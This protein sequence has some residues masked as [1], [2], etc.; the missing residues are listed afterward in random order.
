MA[1]IAL[2]ARSLDTV[3]AGLHYAYPAA[4]L[5]YFTVATCA[6]VC[7]L[8]TNRAKKRPA[9]R[10]STRLAVLGLLAAFVLAHAAVAALIVTDSAAHPQDY[11]V[12]G[13]LSCVLV[14]SVLFMKLA[15]NLH[16]VWYPHCG[17]WLLGLAFEATIHSLQFNILDVRQLA[18]AGARCA[19]LILLLGFALTTVKKKHA[20]SDEERQSLLSKPNGAAAGTSTPNGDNA[21]YGSAAQSHDEDN[22]EDGEDD[23]DVSNWERSQAK[24]RKDMKKRLEGDGSWF[25][26][27]KEFALFVPYIWP[28]SLP[29]LQ[30]RAALVLACLLT[31]NL[32]NLLLPRQVAVIVDSLNGTTHANPWVAV[33]AYISLRFASSECGIDLLSQWLWVP[34]K[35]YANESLKRAAFSHMMY[36]SADFHDS[37]ST[38]DLS[39]A[40]N[41]GS[42]VS[43]VIE[44]V[45]MHALPMLVDLGVAVVYLSYTF[46]SYEGLAT[47]ATSIAFLMLAGDLLARTQQASRTRLRAV[48]KESS[49]RWRGFESWTTASTF[50]QIGYEDNRHANAVTN[51]FVEEKKY[52][53]RW[54]CFIALQSVVL[55][56][57]LAVSAYLAVARILAGKATPGQ[58]A[59]L[60]SYWS[61]LS[62]PLKFFSR[63]GKD[64]SD[65]LVEAEMLLRVMQTEPTVQSK[66][67]ARP[68]R[69]EAG[70]VEFDHIS[71]SY[72][73]Q[74]SV[75]NDISLK[76]ERGITVALVGSTGAGKSTLLKL[77]DRFYDVREGSIRIDGQDIRDVEL[78]SL[79]E[80]I[81][82]VP[83]SPILFDDTIMNNVRYGRIT[84][85]DEEVHDACRA[86]C[87]HDKILEFSDGYEAKVGEK[88]VKLSGGELQR[89]AIARVILKR[90]DIVLL[91]EA[92]SAVDTDTEQQI[93]A[94]FQTL[95]RNRTTF[96]VAHR[97]STIMNADLIVVV[98]KGKIIEKGDHES[99]IAV[100]GRYA[101]L[102]SKQAFLKPHKYVEES[103]AQQTG[104]DAETT[105]HPTQEARPMKPLNPVAPTFTP[106]SVSKMPRNGE[107]SEDSMVVNENGRWSDEVAEEE[108]RQAAA[109]SNA[110]KGSVKSKED[111]AT[112]GLSLT[113][114]PNGEGNASADA[115]KFPA[116]AETTNLRKPRYSRRVQS[117]S[118]P[119]ASHESEATEEDEGVLSTVAERDEAGDSTSQGPTPKRAVSARSQ[120]PGRPS[121]D[122][123][124]QPSSSSSDRGSRGRRSRGIR[125][126]RGRGIVRS[127]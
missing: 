42:A 39:L 60:L 91:D 84:A 22:E 80:R 61:Q 81:G 54:N 122:N 14:F 88:G 94:S 6:A 110:N 123:S 9:I 68:L 31:S 32:F 1:K 117:R 56:L 83:Q 92:T 98:E 10:R 116:E 121:T 90:P 12:V 118:E 120:F 71:F 21:R 70:E 17:S 72:D 125:A 76:V 4:I 100:G 27:A 73:R 65:D 106:K 96:V 58:F 97:L 18:L 33:A 103:D 41:G 79:R 85:T 62:G 102:W 2:M 126:R 77:L 119:S 53:M 66:K 75:I 50:N 7:T 99:L 26:F 74:K 107:T 37:K 5:L 20:A 36:L 48:F 47:V 43:S 112:T 29:K 11:V 108:K 113:E 24:A 45:L 44:S 105:T 82:V 93:Q 28:F 34:V 111:G 115:S 15:D 87:I 46:G 49:I 104:P 89:L 59:M 57:G 109:V 63:L 25:E 3:L 114:R 51:R 67:S 95:C 64:I 78:H 55:L 16:P 23:V 30:L 19:I 86:A 13:H 124:V 127:A 35:Y 101:D 69:F 40:I 38:P 8:E 52:I